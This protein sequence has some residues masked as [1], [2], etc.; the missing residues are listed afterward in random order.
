M[1]AKSILSVSDN[2][3]THRLNI[4]QRLKRRVV[5]NRYSIFF[6]VAFRLWNCGNPNK[7]IYWL[8]KW[9]AYVPVHPQKMR[10]G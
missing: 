2:A 1:H 4:L 6:S 3:F 9:K 7:Y 10:M 5:T 8:H